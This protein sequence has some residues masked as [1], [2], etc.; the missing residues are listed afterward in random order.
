MAN[1]VNKLWTSISEA[2][3]P[4]NCLVCDDKKG[5]LCPKCLKKIEYINSN[6][7]P[8]CNKLTRYG[9]VCPNCKRNHHLNGLIAACYFNEPIKKLIY[10]YK[11]R[12]ARDISKLLSRIIIEK[13]T[14]HKIAEKENTIVV[15]IPLHPL[16][17]TKRGFNQAQLIAKDVSTKLKLNYQPEII[18][19]VKLTKTQAKLTREERKE[20]IKDAFSLT[21]KINLKNKDIILIDDVFTTGATLE[22]AAR[23]VKKATA[24]QVWGCV[25]AKR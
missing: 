21:N 4:V 9:Q 1:F 16:S 6:S 8:F 15:P 25:V 22:E 18:K 13:I 12:K 23:T 11:Y 24:R 17:K 20:N 19:R 14:G 3:F 10:Q 2:I 7:C 5:W